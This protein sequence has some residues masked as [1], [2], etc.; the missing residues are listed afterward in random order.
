MPGGS[1]YLIVGRIRRAHG[2][3]GEVIVDPLTDSPEHVF[4]PGRRLLASDGRGQSPSGEAVTV[5][6]SRSHAGGLVVQFAGLGDRTAAEGWRDRYLLAPAADLAP[7]APGEVYLH[8]LPGMR[9]DLASGESVGT[10]NAIVEL[11]QGPAIEIA[12]P[13][14]Q[15]VLVP[16]AP[17][18]VDID[19]V[20]RVVW[21]D[22]VSGLLD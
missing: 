10:V 16:Y 21:I 13:G 3:R 20:A 9:V 12:R 4:A 22:A 18:V 1:D 14:R 5:S 7:L 15:P 2:L 11:P 19:R 6:G 8:E 17:C